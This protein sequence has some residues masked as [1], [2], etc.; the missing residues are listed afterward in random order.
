[1]QFYSEQ[2]SFNRLTLPS[3]RD[4]Y[5]YNMSNKNVYASDVNL[6]DGRSVINPQQI[7]V[8]LPSIS[9]LNCYISRSAS[10][11]YSPY[12]V[13]SQ[14]SV[15]ATARTTKK[16]RS[17]SSFTSQK[18]TFPLKC[19]SCQSTETPEWRKGPLG[20]RTLCNACGLIW[21]KLCK[22]EKA[23]KALKDQD[24]CKQMVRKSPSSVST[25]CTS[26]TS[27]TDSPSPSPSLSLSLSPTTIKNNRPTLSFLLS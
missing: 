13:V 16:H 20:P 11:T 22:Q 15:R 6:L 1:M 8:R 17:L 3:I 21:T 24:A 27:M 19:H 25:T 14:Q 7:N 18:V 23:K 12:P 2:Q 9:E 26:T 10:S 5:I 4:D